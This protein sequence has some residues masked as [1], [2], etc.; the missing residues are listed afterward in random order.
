VQV[1][2]GRMGLLFD[3]TTGRRRVC[4]ALIFTAVFSRHMFV[5][6]TFSQ[7]LQDVLAGFERA[8]AFYGGVF[9]W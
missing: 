8:W 7:R 1:D 2:F 3:L 4:H 5:W 9:T 6:L